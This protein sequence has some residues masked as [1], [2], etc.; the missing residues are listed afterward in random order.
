MSCFHFVKRSI[1]GIR[2]VHGFTLDWVEVRSIACLEVG[3]QRGFA[4]ETLGGSSNFQVVANGSQQS[5]FSSRVFITLSSWHSRLTISSIHSLSSFDTG[6]SFKTVDTPDSGFALDPWSPL[7]ACVSSVSL[8][9]NAQ[10][11]G[12]KFG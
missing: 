7:L 6:Q 4:R 5:V 8:K 3:W 10:H 11:F 2:T 9:S 12:E 1:L